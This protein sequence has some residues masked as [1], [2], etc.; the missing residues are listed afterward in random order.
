MGAL[1]AVGVL[2]MIISGRRHETGL[3]SRHDGA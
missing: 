1:I 2:L 3:T